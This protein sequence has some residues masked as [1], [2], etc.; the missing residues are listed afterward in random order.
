V[1][2][3]ALVHANGNKTE[4]A[5]QRGALLDKRPALMNIWATYCDQR[6]STR[7]QR[8]ATEKEAVL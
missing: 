1:I 4:A 7:K 5:Y 8:A 6:P 3:A 2:E